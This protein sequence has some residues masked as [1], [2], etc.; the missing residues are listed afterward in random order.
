M[1]VRCCGHAAAVLL[2]EA[3]LTRVIAK[4]TIEVT[5]DAYGNTHI[6]FRG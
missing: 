6:D 2:S 5:I 4:V 3:T 1:R